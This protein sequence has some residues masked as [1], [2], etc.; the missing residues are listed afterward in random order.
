MSSI[1]WPQLSVATAALA[2]GIRMVVAGAGE[3]LRSHALMGRL[4]GLLR[5]LRNDGRAAGRADFAARPKE[6]GRAGVRCWAIWARKE[7]WGVFL[8]SFPFLLFQSNFQNILKEFE[9]ILNFC[10]NHTLH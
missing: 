2:S 8:F 9:F 4:L 1:G 3:G 5:A 10:Q 6:R 7:R